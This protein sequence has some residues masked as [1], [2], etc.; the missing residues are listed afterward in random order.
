MT[1][2]KAQARELAKEIDDFASMEGFD[3][4]AAIEAALVAAEKR[5]AAST[6][7]ALRVTNCDDHIIW[8]EGRMFISHD[9]F[10]DSEWA[11]LTGEVDND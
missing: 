4:V 2:L 10:T 11:A 6:R 3:P 1:D 9:E 7:K 8:L 5:G